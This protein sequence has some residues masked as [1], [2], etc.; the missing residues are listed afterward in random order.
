MLPGAAL[1]K[2]EDDRL[3][4]IEGGRAVAPEVSLMRLAFAGLEHVLQTQYVGS[5]G[6]ESQ[7]CVYDKAA[8]S[9]LTSLGRIF[10]I[11]FRPN[12]RA[13]SLQARL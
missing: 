4:R 10:L 7:H 1:G 2:V 12:A 11:G 9:W 6:S 13:A 3:D 8:R 5:S